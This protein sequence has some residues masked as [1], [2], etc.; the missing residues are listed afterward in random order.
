MTRDEALDVVAMVSAAWSQQWGLDEM[1]SYARGIMAGDCE[2]VCKAVLRAQRETRF[3]PSV[4]EL[5]ERARVE[6]KMAA[7]ADHHNIPAE[8]PFRPEWTLRWARARAV[9]DGR[10]FPEQAHAM[11][12]QE[13]PVPDTMISDRDAWVQPDEYLDGDV[14][15]LAELMA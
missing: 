13:T 1:E 8:K 15:T 10:P 4:A 14:P 7:M 12:E 2:N 5:L 11:R 6:R 3:R 9:D